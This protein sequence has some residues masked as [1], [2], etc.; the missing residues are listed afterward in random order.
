M[1]L[2]PP[3]ARWAT[4]RGTPQWSPRGREG[5]AGGRPEGRRGDG[6]ADS[7]EDRRG[8]GR[9]DR[10]GPESCASILGLDVGKL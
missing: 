10:R 1:R 2:R 9:R 6:R 4:G 5:K 7:R 3:R 8:G